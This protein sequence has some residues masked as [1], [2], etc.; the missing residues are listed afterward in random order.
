MPTLR[1]L[2]C[3][4]AVVDT[5]SVTAAAQ[6]LHASQPAVS[7]QLAGLEREVGVPL[8]D[9]LPRGVV[10]TSAGRRLADRARV[11]LE[12]A[13]QGVADAR[14]A[15]TATVRV[16]CVESF[17]ATLLPRALRAWWATAP[18]SRVA[19]TEAVSA[20]ALVDALVRDEIDV[21]V[22]PSPTSAPG[23]RDI[24]GWEVVAVTAADHRLA[25]QATV[26]LVALADEP[27][28]QLHADN[29]LAA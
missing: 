14:D 21:A 17:T 11:A 29:A 27:M 8:L 9:R 7:H 24:V 10:P 19:L 16:G 23:P 13:A 6:R 20:D 3:L 22:T 5:G 28:L 12:A 15:D 18:D 1:A 26:P 4:V 25:A 2:E